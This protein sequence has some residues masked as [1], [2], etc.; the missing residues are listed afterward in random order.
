MPNEKGLILEG[1]CGIGQ[2]VHAFKCQ[3]YNAV[4]IDF[5][6]ETIKRVKAAVPDLDVRLGDIRNLPFRDGEI[7]GYW[8]FGVIEHFWEGYEKIIDEMKRVIRNG[9]YLFITFPYM[10]P[11][12]KCKVS[13]GLYNRDVDNCETDK[14]YQFALD[15]NKVI[16]DLKAIGFTFVEKV[17]FDGVKGFKDEVKVSKPL[18]QKIYD[19]KILQRYRATIDKLLKPFASHMMLL[20]MQRS[21]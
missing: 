16:F 21:C 11:L 8:S 18:L 13:L 4:G 19:G 5:A 9:G 7:A 20:V 2:M 3:G 14:F 10:S 1:G 15:Y 12:R 17:P 6:G